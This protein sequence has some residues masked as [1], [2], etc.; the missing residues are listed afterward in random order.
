[1]TTSKNDRV[2]GVRTA[3]F[4]VWLCVVWGHS[5]MSGDVSSAESSRFVFLVRP[6]FELFGCHD[7]MIMTFA[8][9]K[10]AHFSEYAI[11]AGLGLR[12]ARAW[13]ATKRGAWLLAGAIGVAVPVLDELLQTIV[14]G[15]SGNPR[16][17]LIDM[18]GGAFGMLVVS[19]W[20]RWV[21]RRELMRP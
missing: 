6:L 11:L 16:D 10:C 13:C 20:E 12:M 8:I 2:R 19:C 9:R 18:A 1:M 7:E 21:Q 17:V 4:V 3:A 14:P 5:L 15:R